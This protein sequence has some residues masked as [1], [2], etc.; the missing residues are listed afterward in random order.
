MCSMF[1]RTLTVCKTSISGSNPDGASILINNLGT[2][3]RCACGRCEH[4]CEHDTASSGADRVFT[5]VE[6]DPVRPDENPELLL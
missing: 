2:R 4:E 3:H 5:L 6:L 1:R